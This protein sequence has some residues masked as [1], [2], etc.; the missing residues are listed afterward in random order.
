MAVG[1]AVV[2]LVVLAALVVS[3]VVLFVGLLT[4]RSRSAQQRHSELVPGRP[5]GAPREWALSH[6]PE[7]RL[8]RRMVDALASVRAVEPLGGLAVT[9]LRVQLELYAELLDQR[10]V[11]ASSVTGTVHGPALDAVAR[12]VDELEQVAGQ[13]VVLASAGSPDPGALDALGGR[14]RMLGPGA[15]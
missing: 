11:G 8:H 12:D 2:V 13:V 1:V 9:D 7:A 6:D 3:G 4:Q 5:G 14:L 10:L 15:G